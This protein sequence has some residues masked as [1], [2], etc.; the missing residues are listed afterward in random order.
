MATNLSLREW[1]EVGRTG[2]GPAFTCGEWPQPVVEQADRVLAISRT[3]AYLRFH[4]WEAIGRAGSILLA[5]SGHKPE[6]A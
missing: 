3:P 4:V 1:E 2:S 6:A 5:G